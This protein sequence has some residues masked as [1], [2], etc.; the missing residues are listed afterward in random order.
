[1]YKHEKITTRQGVCHFNKGNEKLKL[2]STFNA[3][4]QKPQ[5]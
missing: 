5:N 1:M 4:L 3:L 2:I